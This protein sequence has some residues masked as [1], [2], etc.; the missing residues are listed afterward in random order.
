M[1]VVPYYATTIGSGDVMAKEISYEEAVKQVPVIGQPH[2]MQI[3]VMDKVDPQ[4]LLQVIRDMDRRITDL[5][6]QVKEQ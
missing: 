2:G 1:G 5:E 4:H 6:R 3:A